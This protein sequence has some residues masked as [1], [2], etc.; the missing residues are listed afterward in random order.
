MNVRIA[1]RGY[2]KTEI[3]VIPEDWRVKQLADFALVQTGPFGTL[4]KA[5]EYS[6]YDGVPLISVGEIR[7]GY[8]RVTI[9][10]PRVSSI[11][12][13][14][15]PQYILRTGDIVFGRK[16][17]IDRSALI[18]APEDGWFLGSDGLRVRPLPGHD[19]AYISL[20]FQ[21]ARVQKWLIQN[22]L[23]TTMPSLNQSI[24]K[25]VCIA[26]PADERE[27]EAIAEAF[28]DADA[29]IEALEQAL[30]K[31][32]DLKQG[33]MQ[34]LLAGNRRLP[35]FVNP[36]VH[37]RLSE[38]ASIRNG[39]T[40]STLRS[41]FWDGD[42]PW[43]T[44]TDITALQGGKYL[45][46]TARKI[47]QMGLENSSAELIPANS[48]VMT[49]RAT[50]GEC[51][52]NDV[53]LSTNQGFKNFLPYEGVNTEF[54]YY[55]LTTKKKD[56]IRLCGGSTFLEI[57]KAQLA[58]FAVYLPTQKSEQAEIAEILSDMDAEIEALEQKLAKARA[59]KQGMMQQLLTGQVRLI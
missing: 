59:V 5:S 7:Q 42:I 20:Q 57:G 25:R 21:T 55:L 14:R 36:W 19:S 43:C 49:S 8:L 1:T 24:L 41:E 3:G 11:V 13:K 48:I 54:L 52:I 18:R 29:F 6:E 31:K 46:E 27:Q 30:A 32:R 2:K 26:F 35:G 16:G 45:R 50:I 4:L 15:L 28:A 38:L 37:T 56:F 51:A 58:K 10:T 40:P 47:T 33:A 17:G 22:A 9:E 23:G 12:T 39:G 44:P 34:E 53:P